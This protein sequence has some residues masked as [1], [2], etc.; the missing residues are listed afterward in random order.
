MGHI[1]VNLIIMLKSFTY[2]NLTALIIFCFMLSVNIAE[3]IHLPD[4][5]KINK[6]ETFFTTNGTG[7]LL[8]NFNKQRH[9]L[10]M[11]TTKGI[12]SVRIVQLQSETEYFDFQDCKTLYFKVEKNGE[13]EIDEPV[14]NYFKRWKMRRMTVVVINKDF[15]DFS[16]LTIT[17]YDSVQP[18]NYDIDVLLDVR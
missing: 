18:F 14:Y 15:S 13:V 7:R 4:S 10:T 9:I 16:N 6:E 3:A 12:R 11:D 17:L 2:Y 8:V 1:S 5:V